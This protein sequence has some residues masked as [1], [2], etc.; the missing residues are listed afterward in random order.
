MH[1]L[2]SFFSCTSKNNIE[3]PR[4][5]PSS[6][7]KK[8]K[9]SSSSQAEPRATSASASTTKKVAA[10]AAAPVK[11]AK[12]VEPVQA[13]DN[14]K[15]IL[16]LAKGKNSMQVFLYDAEDGHTVVGMT[17]SAME[18]MGIFD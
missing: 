8:K 6:K 15:A 16:N 14:S 9:S 1:I 5:K 10:A 13:K 7:K 18:D 11:K 3:P 2:T 4:K 17:E 12:K